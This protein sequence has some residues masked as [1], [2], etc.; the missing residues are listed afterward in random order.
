M[1]SP[2][3]GYS[4]LLRRLSPPMYTRGTVALGYPVNRTEPMDET[5][6]SLLDRLKTENDSET[7]NRLHQ[8]YAPL[9]RSWLGKYDIQASDMD[10]VIQEVLMTVAAEGESFQHNGRTGAFRSWLRSILVNRLRS[11]W[12]ARGRRPQADGGSEIANRINQL[13]DPGSELSRLWDRQHDQY[14]LQRLLTISESKFS[15]TT[16]KAFYH[17][18]ILHERPDEVAANLDISLNAVFIAKS[19]VL[20]KLRQEADGLVE[21]SGEIFPNG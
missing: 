9:L 7:W 13:E 16:W 15:P 21:L 10:D 11:F 12:R 6:L 4:A 20:S 18:T 1:L 5:S 3:R 2:L 19:R 14:V 17:V 8:L